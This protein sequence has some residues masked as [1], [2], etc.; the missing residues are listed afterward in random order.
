[1]APIISRPTGPVT[2]DAESA[3]PTVFS[4]PG[5]SH[6]IVLVVRQLPETRAAVSSNFRTGSQDVDGAPG[7]EC[8]SG[9][10]PSGETIRKRRKRWGK[11]TQRPLTKAVV[12][13][14]SSGRHTTAK[15]GKAALSVTLEVIDGR[16]YPAG[17]YDASN[18]SPK[19]MG[20]ANSIPL[21]R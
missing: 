10:G 5:I 18:S 12:A 11:G 3:R 7:A 9:W 16:A 1:M 2:S 14:T 17:S 19:R 20:V 13:A 6:R 15:Y 4:S 8:A 21:N